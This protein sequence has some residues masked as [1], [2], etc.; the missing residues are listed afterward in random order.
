MQISLHKIQ[1][2]YFSFNNSVLQ[3][4]VSLVLQDV[5]SRVDLHHVDICSVDPPGMPF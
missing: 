3:D 1:F 4:V 5:Q 2:I